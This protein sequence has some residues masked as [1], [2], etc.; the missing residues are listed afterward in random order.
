[1]QVRGPDVPLIVKNVAQQVG[2]GYQPCSFCAGGPGPR[3]ESWAFAL[4]WQGLKTI[5]NAGALVIRSCK[6]C[7]GSNSVVVAGEYGV[8]R[9]L[10]DAGYNVATLMSR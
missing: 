5:I 3:L 4:D 8:T 1:M 9:A 10:I 7:N 6:L 2:I